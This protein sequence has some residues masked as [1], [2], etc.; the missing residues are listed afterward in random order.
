MAIEKMLSD[1]RIT[2]ILHEHKLCMKER[3]LYL[4]KRNVIDTIEQENIFD[5]YRGVMR[6]FG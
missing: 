3:M 4:S 6:N 5:L 2:Y 1:V